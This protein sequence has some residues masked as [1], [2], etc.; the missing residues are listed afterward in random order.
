MRLLLDTHAFLWFIDGNPRFSTRAREI[1]EDSG[2]TRFVSM[3][4]VWEIAI[5]ISIRKLILSQP[6]HSL[7]REQL[8]ENAFQILDIDT[9]HVE[10]VALLPF[11]HRDP[12]DRML[13]AQAVVEQVPI[14]SADTAFDQ[15]PVARIW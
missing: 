9:T 4:S 5:K 11:H 15:Y 12:F 1:I 7:V 14:I 2:N 3:A 13:I 8:L 10:R 6:L